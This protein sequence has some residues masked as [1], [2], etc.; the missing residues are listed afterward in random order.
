ME[1]RQSE[2]R[3]KERKDIN[4]TE[5]VGKADLETRERQKKRKGLKAHTNETK[6]KS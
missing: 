3:R 6:Q 2:K 4:Q 1:R 5:G